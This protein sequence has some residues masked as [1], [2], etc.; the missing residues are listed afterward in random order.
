VDVGV[1]EDHSDKYLFIVVICVFLI[2]HVSIKGG[3][4]K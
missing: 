3:C 4:W 1:D 2:I